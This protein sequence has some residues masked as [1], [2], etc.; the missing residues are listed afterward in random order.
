MARDVYT[1]LFHDRNRFQSDLT[2]PGS[3]ALNFKSVA[4]SCASKPSAIW[5]RAE[6]PVQRIKTRFF[7]TFPGGHQSA[8]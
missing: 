6:L 5:L 2:R 3:G 7:M 4:A 1:D 8:T